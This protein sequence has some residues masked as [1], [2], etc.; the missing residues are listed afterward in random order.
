[1]TVLNCVHCDCASWWGVRVPWPPEAITFGTADGLQL[2]L[3]CP[4]R[5]A[6]ATS[7]HT[8]T[9]YAPGWV[10]QLGPFT[11]LHHRSS[12]RH[13]ALL[14][15]Q[16]AQLIRVT[17]SACFL[18]FVQHLPG[19]LLIDASLLQG[20]DIVTLFALLAVTSAVVGR[21]LYVPPG[22]LYN[23]PAM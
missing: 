4:R 9:L 19:S 16:L 10:S 21:V 2:Q 5:K 15:E 3:G 1:M 14:Q 6:Y 7:M 12:D 8:L 17:L 20:L 22:L 18:P 23:M 13:Q 11:H